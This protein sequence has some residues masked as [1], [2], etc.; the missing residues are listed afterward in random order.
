MKK[1]AVVLALVASVLLPSA[2]SAQNKHVEGIVF[3]DKDGDGVR[4][5]KEKGVQ[6]VPVSDGFSVVL[7]DKDGK[8]SLDLNPKARFVTVYTP[9]GYRN[10]NRFFTD[11]RDLVA[12][13]K[14]SGKSINRSNP[15]FDFGLE[16]DAEFGSF[17]HMSDI[18]ERMYE[19]WIDRVIDYSRVHDHDFVAITGDICYA[20]GLVLMSKSINDRTM[21]CRVVYTI[22][23]HDLIKGNEDYLG[24]P[25]GEKNYE[26]CFGP[27]WYA[28]ASNGVHFIVTP[29]MAGDAK[30]SYGYEDIQN[31]IK[32]YMAVIPSGSPMIFFNHDANERLIPADGNVKAFVY[33]HRHTYFNRIS[34]SGIPFYCSTASAKAGNDHSAAALR[35]IFFDREGITSTRLRYAPLSNH[36]AAHIASKDGRNTLSAVA[37]D[38]AAETVTVSAVLADG[39]KYPLRRQDDM[40]W[41]TAVPE[42]VREGGYTVTAEFSDGERAVSGEI[43][44]P[45]LKWMNSVGSKPYLA[46]PLLSDGHLYIATIDNEMT[47]HCG[48]YALSAKDGAREWYFHT[49]N[50]VHG[51]IALVD[52]V[53]YAA[54]ADYNL[55]AINAADGSL[56]WKIHTAAT[57]YPSLTEGVHVDDGLVYFG[58]GTNLCAVNA[59]DGSVVWKNVYKN[60]GSI[61]N[62]GTDRTAAGALLTNGYWVGRFCYDQKTGD[63]L[64]EHRDYQN[65]YSTCTPAVVDTTFI[66]AGYNALM[67]VG[68]R[69]CEILKVQEYPTIF[70]VKSEPLVVGDKVFIGTS[71][72]GVLAANLE[73]LSKAWE[74]TQCK[75]ALIYTSPYTHNQEKTV[76]CSIV[77]YKDCVIFGANDGYV[78]CLNQ[79]NG[80]FVWRIDVGLPVISKPIISGD[81]LIVVDFA[82]NIL[83]YDMGLLF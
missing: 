30:P 83:C 5:G 34:D 73:D 57:F 61:T 15:G 58:T 1:I 9:S 20:D 76:E 26:D 10:T 82:G 25:Y 53:I 64:W 46:N 23:N 51:D 18:E 45:A 27:S 37:Y 3:L 12:G 36:I 77:A 16:K 8:Y 24:N 17:A 6:S 31:W 22:G 43:V 13:S 38:E 63:L 65:R 35:Q 41:Q 50:S 68:A 75:P 55:Y 79:S 60:H 74:Y 66:Y 48:V 62:V 2:L 29:M 71:P 21:G 81:D 44:E 78:Y 54:D 72:H 80:R 69:S 14:V 33:G 4:S 42:G 49:A 59:A 56:K 52:G 32:A 19:D 70:N 47:E 67:Q 40:M 39:T 11:V 28:F 7:T